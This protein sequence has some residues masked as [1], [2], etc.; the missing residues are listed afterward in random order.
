M[1]I[2][3][4]NGGDKNVLLLNNNL[5]NKQYFYLNFTTA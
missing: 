3:A 4:E 2:H 5:D 1:N